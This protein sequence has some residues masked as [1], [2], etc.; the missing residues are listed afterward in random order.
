MSF[1]GEAEVL[2]IK[3]HAPQA[4]YGISVT[5]YNFTV[6][7]QARIMELIIRNIW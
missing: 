4:K 6:L 2:K 7:I 1:D 3:E 5:L